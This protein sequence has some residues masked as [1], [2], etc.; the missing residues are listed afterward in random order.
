MEG[1]TMTVR[2][3]LVQVTYDGRFLVVDFPFDQKLVNTIK[4]V[5]GSVWNKRISKKWTVPKGSHKQLAQAFQS[6]IRWKTKEEINKSASTLKFDEET[7]EDVLSRVPSP[8]ETPFLKLEPFEFQ[9][10]M[11]GWG[12]TPKGKKT[13]IYGG[14]LA[15]LMG[16]GKTLQAIG[17][18]GYLKYSPPEELDPIKRVLIICPAS[19]KIQWGEEIEK[20][21]DESY[22]IIDGG[23][24]TTKKKAFEK[25]M[26]QYKRVQEEEIFFTIVNYELLREKERLGKEKVR[27]GYKVE[28][29]IVFGDYIDLNA[30]LDNEYDMIIIDEAHRM[31]N[32]KSE[33]TKVIQKIQHPSVRL[34]MT[35]TP[36]DK[37]LP[38]IFPLLDYLSP[39]ILADSSLS[40]EE[41]K[42]MFEDQF[43]VMGWNSFALKNSGGKLNPEFLE[44]VDVKN[45][46]LLNKK[47]SPF[48]LRRLTEDVSDEMPEAIG[49]NKPIIVGWDQDQEAIYKFFLTK[50]KE[51]MEMLHEAK[52]EEEA[53]RAKAEKHAMLLYMAEA[54]DTPELIFHSLSP[55]PFR[56][57]REMKK[58]RTLADVLWSITK[59]LRKLTEIQKQHRDTHGKN[60]PIVD[61][62][63]QELHSER[64]QTLASL[65]FSSPKLERI[66]DIVNNVVVEN[67]EKIVIFT[68]YE[69]MAQILHRELDKHLNTHKNGKRKK[70]TTGIKLY[71]GKTDKGC[72]W[73]TKLQ[74][75]K[76]D[77]RNLSCLDCP[78]KTS[79]NSQTKSAWHFQNDPETKV[80]IANDAANY[81]VNLH[82]GSHLINVDLPHSYSVFVQRNG[83]IRRLGSEHKLVTIHNI[84][85]QNS[86]EVAKFQ[87]LF[88]QKDIQD[89]IVE[90]SDEQQKFL[91]DALEQFVIHEKTPL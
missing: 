48:K 45:L 33:T 5:K 23:N 64:H 34:L 24:A 35:G 52:T 86:L 61:H 65:T 17:L 68:F 43:L 59:E 46:A 57:L 58:Y 10:L 56:K 89:T 49:A 85:T 77:A 2:E 3:S 15:D 66:K 21:T 82:K 36:I 27:K 47:I 18:A 25:R 26:E 55:L 16:L 11:I 51:T 14:L 54:C 42:N 28:N 73:K 88:K 1:I 71:T 39:D 75:E 7:L 74:E 81:G 19:L 62:R 70:E 80:I 22:M 63:I 50:F 67:G 78:L 60:D 44:P 30:V 29:K 91:E 72:A 20:F 53:E 8:I 6:D 90:N 87:T 40:F 84:L 38:N 41:R 79:C 4:S 9:K 37:D 32:P 31:K 69:R 12:A 76:K 13:K 83:R